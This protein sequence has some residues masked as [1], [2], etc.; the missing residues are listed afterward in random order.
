M[1]IAEKYTSLAMIFRKILLVWQIRIKETV[2]NG[3]MKH[4]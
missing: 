3:K 2:A 1:M 4:K